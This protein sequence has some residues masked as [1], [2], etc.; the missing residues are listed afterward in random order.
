[1]SLA[2]SHSAMYESVHSDA[3]AVQL[4][5]HKVTVH[6]QHYTRLSE[7]PVRVELIDQQAIE[8]HHAQNLDEALRYTAGVH[9]NLLSES[10]VGGCKVM[11]LIVSLFWL[12]VILSRS[13]P[14]AV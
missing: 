8:E 7:Q 10:S 14:A 9:K 13:A 1:M 4:V 3:D 11:I 2:V 6:G 12:M 5:A